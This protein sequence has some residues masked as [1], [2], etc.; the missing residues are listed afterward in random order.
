MFGYPGAGKTTTA[1]VI[2]QLTGAV[3]LSSDKK[4]LEMFPNPSFSPQE[5]DTLY[6]ALD[7]QTEELLG[8]G[9]DVIYDANLNRYQHRAEKYAICQKT[10]A[11]PMLIWVKAPKS[12]AKERAAHISRLHLVPEKETPDAMFDRIADVIEEPGPE[13]PYTELDGTKIT[14]QYVAGKLL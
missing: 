14:Q 10:G 2:S 12:L 11:A 1:G 5:H 13:E 3:H 7:T 9:K 4:R 8:Q 6:A